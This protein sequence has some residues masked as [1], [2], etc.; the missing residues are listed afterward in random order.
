MEGKNL[1]IKIV[2][3]GK[4]IV[5]GNIFVKGD[6]TITGSAIYADYDNGIN[7]HKKGKQIWNLNADT[8]IKGHNIYAGVYVDQGKDF[9]NVNE[10]ANGNKQVV[11]IDQGN[12]STTPYQYKDA[13]I[14]I[15]E[16]GSSG[17]LTSDGKVKYDA[18]MVA[19]SE[20]R[21]NMINSG[22]KD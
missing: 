12:G 15:T 21:K 6:V 10:D 22:K 7:E 8:N 11:L 13:S 9:Y 2:N 1:T 5:G 14:V 4:M 17:N 18:A 16:V 19:S 20:E 3:N